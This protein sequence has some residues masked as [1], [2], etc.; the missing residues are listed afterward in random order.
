M[1]VPVAPL[2]FAGAGRRLT[3]IDIARAA[4]VLG[5][6][7]ATVEAVRAVEA[8]AAGGFLL[9][10]TGRPQILFEAHRFSRETGGRF[11]A[12]HPRLSVPSWDRTL[13]F[14]GAREYE[15]LHAAI[16][17]D[18]KAALKAASWGL[19]Q[20][21][22]SNHKLAGYPD[23]ESYVAAM[24]DSE[25]AHLDAFV[26]FCQ[27]AGLDVHLRAL[28]WAGFARGYNGTGYALNAYDVKLAAAYAKAKGKSGAPGETLRIGA[29]GWS[30][31]ELQRLLV[32]AGFKVMVDGMFGRGTDVVVQQ[33]QQARGL[34]P[35]G[36]VGPATWEALWRDVG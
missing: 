1:E 36:I 31:T 3:P 32:Q 17:L 27:A 9:D 14:G 33:F 29:Q 19:F 13:Y 10:G 34:K 11:N 6:E 16:E 18:R 15:R 4:G 22:G 24:R 35:D 26:A 8:G 5:C 25:G 20:I 21:L 7:V 28:N 12:S 2:P 30:V 23:V